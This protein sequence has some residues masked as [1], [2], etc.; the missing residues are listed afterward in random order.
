MDKRI[1][2]CVY[3]SGGDFTKEYV[4]KLYNSF[5]KFSNLPE[6]NFYCL[7]DV[8]HEFQDVKFKVIKLQ[9]N[10]PGWWSKLELF[11][12]PMKGYQ[13]VYVDLDTI[14]KDDISFLFVD[15]HYFTMLKDFNKKVVRIASGVMI[16][17]SGEH[18]ELL[19]RVLRKEINLDA[20]DPKKGGK[21]GDQ[22][23]L[24][25]YLSVEVDF[26][27]ERYPGIVASYKWASTQEKEDAAIICYHGKPRPHETN[28][29]V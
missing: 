24:E 10:L 1:M 5:L 18:T 29:S 15:E 21:L 13:I 25:D 8:P 19:D 12:L 17:K 2:T 23:Y 27:Q 11:G 26:L 3:K 28:W 7:T 22:A 9:H 6:E 4:I 20:Y 16:F 14:I